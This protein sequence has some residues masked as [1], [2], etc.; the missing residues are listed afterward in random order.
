VTNEETAV[1]QLILGISLEMPASPYQGDGSFFG[2]HTLIALMRLSPL[3]IFFASF[4]VLFGIKYNRPA[5]KTI[6]GHGRQSL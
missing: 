5:D 1:K 3:Q 4:L 2:I 6:Y